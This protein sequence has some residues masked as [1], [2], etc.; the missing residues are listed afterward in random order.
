MSFLSLKSSH[1]LNCLSSGDNFT[2]CS[3]FIGICFG[4]SFSK[5]VHNLPSLPGSA[6][7]GHFFGVKPIA[8]DEELD[9]P[10]AWPETTAIVYYTPELICI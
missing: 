9:V 5:K 2:I 8:S 10:Y 4:R 7:P 3:G 6:V 1:T